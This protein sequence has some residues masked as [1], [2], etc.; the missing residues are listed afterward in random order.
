MRKIARRIARVSSSLWSKDV[1]Q[2]CRKDG[3]FHQCRVCS[4]YCSKCN[5]C[6]LRRCKSTLVKLVVVFP[7]GFAGTSS[8]RKEQ[9]WR[10]TGLQSLTYDTSLYPCKLMGFVSHGRIKTLACALS[11]LL[12]FWFTSYILQF[13]WVPYHIPLLPV[14]LLTVKIANDFR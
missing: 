6:S 7:T 8:L 9:R 14:C 11:L 4:A 3:Q 10:Q 5:K 12:F 13:P 1:E 2:T